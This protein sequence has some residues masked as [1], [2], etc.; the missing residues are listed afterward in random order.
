MPKFIGHPALADRISPHPPHSLI[1]T[2]SIWRVIVVRTAGHPRID[3]D[4]FRD[5][6]QE[7]WDFG[8]SISDILDLINNELI[9]QDQVLAYGT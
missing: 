3:I 4:R 8:L 2:Q 5:Q 9:Q 6:I 1:L 7:A